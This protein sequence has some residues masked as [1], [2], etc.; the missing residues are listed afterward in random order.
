MVTTGMFHD[1]TAG[2]LVGDSSGAEVSP[3][4]RT[5]GH[6]GVAFVE[7]LHVIVLSGGNGW[8]FFLARPLR[9][10]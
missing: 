4:S 5:P 9:I 6:V 1:I 2:Q 10:N 8:D 7:W 3:D